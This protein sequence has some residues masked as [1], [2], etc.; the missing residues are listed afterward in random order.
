MQNKYEGIRFIDSE[1]EEAIIEI[2]GPIGADCFTNPNEENT[3][4]KMSEELARIKSLNAKTINVRINSLGGDV[5]HALAIHD[6]LAEHPARIITQINGLCASAATIIAMA[7][8]E[9]RM[10]RNALFLIHQCSAYIGRAN[11]EQLASELEAQRSVNARLLTIYTQGDDT[12]SDK[13]NELMT[14]NSGQGRWIDAEE[15]KSLGFATDIYNDNRRA[16]TFPSSV[17]SD[18]NLPEPPQTDHEESTDEKTGRRIGQFIDLLSRFFST[19]DY[20]KKETDMK[21]KFPIIA[22]TINMTENTAFDLSKGATLSEENLTMLE[23][24]LSQKLQN[25]ETLSAENNTL[26]TER[27]RLKAI[28]DAFPG[29]NPQVSGNDPQPSKEDNIETYVSASPLYQALKNEI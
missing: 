25:I 27:D 15:A 13:M 3:V 5:S 10:S 14:A 20:T 6:L 18:Y 21:E 29:E 4:R 9:R 2:Y 23:G 24:V 28:L 1:G 7:G 26:K 16:A 8:T 22:A 11:A 19:Q 17:F 12:L